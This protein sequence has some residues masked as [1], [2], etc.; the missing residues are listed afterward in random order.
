M[1][2]RSK[3]IAQIEADISKNNIKNL[4]DQAKKDEDLKNKRIDNLNEY[5]DKAKEGIS[6]I[7]GFV[8]ALY[9]GEINKIEEDQKAYD[10]AAQAKIDKIE[11]HIEKGGNI[12]IDAPISVT[13]GDKN[14]GVDINR[15]LYGLVE[16]VQR[17]Q[18]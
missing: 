5:A 8:N 10:D 13:G 15:H 3:E 16:K 17:R 4:E 11:E 2:F 14:A 7:T 18:K 1:L 12:N 9:E 6:A